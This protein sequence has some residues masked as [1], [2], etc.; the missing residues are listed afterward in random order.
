MLQP[1]LLQ[2]IL[3]SSPSSTEQITTGSGPTPELRV[4]HIIELFGFCLHNIY[5][6]FKDK[7]YKK[8]KGAAMGSPVS[9]IIAY[10]F[11]ENFKEWALRT[12]GNPLPRL[13][14][15][16][17]DDTFIMQQIEHK[18]NSLRHVNSIDQSIQYM[19]Q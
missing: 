4:Q 13:W 14:R 1:H 10:L 18:E 16:C 2:D 8:V 3:H 5:F 19:V 15:R 6:I 9:P 17:I 11:M 12:V 7:D